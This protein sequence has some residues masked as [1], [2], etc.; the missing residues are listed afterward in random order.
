MKVLIDTNVLVAAV[1]FPEGVAR[2]ALARAIESGD[3]IVCDYAISELH[4]VFERKFPTS[5]KLLPRFMAYLSSGVEIVATPD[6]TGVGEPLLRDPKDQPI[7]SA[8]LA[9]DAGVSRPL[10]IDPRTFLPR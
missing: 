1:L 10:A 7:L 3:A 8:A 9:A 6:R 2:Q 5:T 4:D